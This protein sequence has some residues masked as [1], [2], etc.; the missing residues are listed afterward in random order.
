V[1]GAL[2]FLSVFVSVAI[3]AACGGPAQTAGTKSELPLPKFAPGPWAAS[4]T[5]G[6][7]PS[8]PEQCF[9]A[10]DDNC[11]G[12]IDEGCGVCTG[13]LQFTIAWAEASVDVNLLVVDPSGVKV[14]KAK[15]QSSSASGL[16]LDRDCP[17]DGCAGQNVENVCSEA[18]DPPRGRYVMEVR[19]VPSPSA[20]T[21][22]TKVRVGV[23]V[24]DR[25]YGADLELSPLK[26]VEEI[27][28]VL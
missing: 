12:V 7:T 1:R 4:L 10:T 28:F 14:E 22:A 3:A 26:Q 15:K 9:N 25:T 24:G 16:V 17:G 8:G 13:P 21:P 6:C 18:P 2:P 11:N 19:L 20:V 5:A 23:R 27:S